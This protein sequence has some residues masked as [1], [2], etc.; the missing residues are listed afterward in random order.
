MESI[1]QTEF[2]LSATDVPTNNATRF[3]VQYPNAHSFAVLKTESDTMRHSH[4]HKEMSDHPID[5]FRHVVLQDAEA[6][7]LGHAQ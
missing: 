3:R 4:P 1:A 5:A 7:L 6:D 2:F